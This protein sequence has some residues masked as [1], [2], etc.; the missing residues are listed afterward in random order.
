[1]T[2]FLPWFKPV[3]GQLCWGGEDVGIN[4]W[5]VLQIGR[6]H[7]DVADLP[8]SRAPTDRIVLAR[9][10]WT[11]TIFDYCDWTLEERGR[12]V[13]GS[14]STRR[15]R[16]AGD[17]LTG[18]KLVD[19]TLAARSARTQFAFD[20]GAIL[21]TIPRDRRSYQWSLRTPGVRRGW[22]R[23]PLDGKDLVFRAD[24]HYSYERWRAGAADKIRCRAA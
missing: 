14:S 23:S 11:L 19:V 1:M 21:T 3:L 9:G 24:R 6:P 8:S 4:G 12:R 17:V 15:S 5:L 22:R 20:L 18:Q 13:G 2:A 16:L 10:Q 7:L